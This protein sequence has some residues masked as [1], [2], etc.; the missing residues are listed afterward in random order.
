V[1]GD[2]LLDLTSTIGAEAPFITVEDAHF[3]VTVRS[4]S[5]SRSAPFGEPAAYPTPDLPN[6]LILAD[7]DSDGRLDLFA[8]VEQGLEYWRGQEGGRFAQ[9]APLDS[10]DSLDPF[11]GTPGPQATDWNGDGVLDLVYAAYGTVHFRLGRGDGTFDAEVA[12]ALTAGVMGDVD[13]DNRPDMVSGSNL[14]LGIDGCHASKLVPLPDWPKQ[15]GLAL[16]DLNGDGNLDIVADDNTNIIVRVGDGQGGFSQSL[17]MPA[18]DDGPW[19]IG[20][21]LIGDLNRDGKLDFVYTRS[22]GWG[23]FLNTCQ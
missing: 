2:G 19:P 12:C 13:H 3:A 9:Q 1:D 16:A 10:Q 18:H 4:G 8:G 5:G 21:F 22:D 14:L 23:V 20:V 15:G 7:L 6:S 11:A 17:S